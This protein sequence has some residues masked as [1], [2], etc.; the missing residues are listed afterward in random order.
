MKIVLVPDSFK[1]TMSSLEIC[2]I[3][4]NKTLEFYPDCDIVTIPVADGGEGTVDSF[5]SAIQ[6]DKIEITVKGPLFQDVPA[7]YGI[8]NDN[9]M[10]VIEMAACAGLPL[11]GENKDPFLATTYGVGQLIADAMNRGCKKIVIGLGGSSTND[12]GAGMAAALG[13]KFLRK[14]GTTF[15]PTG[16]TLNQ[17]DKIDTSEMMAGIKDV[18]FTAMCDVDVPLHGLNGAAHI[19]AKQKGA[20]EEQIV[21]LDEQLQYFDKIVERDLNISVGSIPGA[22]AAGGLGAGVLAFLN[23]RLDKGIDV[24]LDVVGFEQHVKDADIVITGEGKLDDQS[25]RGKV[26][27]GVARRVKPYGIPV[28]AIVGDIGDDIDEA[29]DM[30]VSSVISINR[31]AIPF[32]QAKKRSHKDL[33][34][35]FENLLRLYKSMSSGK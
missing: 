21:E 13:V 1:G 18:E 35:T 9:S 22:G 17:I 32:E 34:L 8:F 23:G 31:V 10:A 25:L 28:L 30:G 20:T 15:V 3:L 16:G 4:S 5:L 29:Y 12:G 24:V 2:E 11:I 14:D 7:Y 19:F 33:A 27:I 6:G 26:V